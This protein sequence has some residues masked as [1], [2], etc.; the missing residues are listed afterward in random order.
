MILSMIWRLC[1]SKLKCIDTPENFLKVLSQY[2]YFIK[3]LILPLNCYEKDSWKV[4]ILKIWWLLMS[5]YIEN[6]FSLENLSDQAQEIKMRNWQRRL[7][8]FCTSWCLYHYKLCKGRG[9]P[10]NTNSIIVKAFYKW[11]IMSKVKV[12]QSK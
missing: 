11:T 4:I 9:W 12:K 6:D 2:Y 10:Q 3:G 5:Y 8:E 7:V 1:I